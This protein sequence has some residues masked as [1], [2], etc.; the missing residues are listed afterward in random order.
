MDKFIQVYDN[1]IDESLSKQLIAMF[2]E[3]PEHHEE[4]VLEG[5]RSFTQVTLQQ[6]AEWRPFAIVLENKFIEY[7]DKYMKDCNITDMMF[8]QKYSFEMIRL[9]RYLPNDVDEFAPH[10][11][12]GNLDS[13]RRFLV[14]FLYLDDNE[15]GHTTFPQWDI[16]VKP[17]TGRMLMFPPMWTHLHA[18]TKPIGKPKYIVGLYLHYVV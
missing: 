15:A 13:A 8:P 16:A 5:H 14:A 10:V 7:I 2:E 1:V 18:G 6:H 4:I 12:V 11:D 3:S 17:E 9:K